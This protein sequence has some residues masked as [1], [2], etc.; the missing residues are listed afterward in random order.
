M[1]FFFSL[2]VEHSA[3]YTFVTTS[4][5]YGFG[6]FHRPHALFLWVENQLEMHSIKSCYWSNWFIYNYYTSKKILTKNYPWWFICF[7]QPKKS[8]CLH[9]LSK[10]RTFITY[11]ITISSTQVDIFR[12]TTFL[13]KVPNVVSQ[14]WVGACFLPHITPIR[15]SSASQPFKPFSI[16]MKERRS[17][18]KYVV[19]CY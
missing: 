12:A 13:M 16:I 3:L 19:F 15:V 14:T 8:Q 10:K 4:F 2:M 5:M 17:K 18:R 9:F 6:E 1:G 7:P 11:V